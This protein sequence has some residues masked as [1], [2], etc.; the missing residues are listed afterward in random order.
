MLELIPCS[1]HNRILLLAA[2]DIETAYSDLTGVHIVTKDTKATTQLTLKVLE[3]KKR[4]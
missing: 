2:A 4:R 1:G 3:E